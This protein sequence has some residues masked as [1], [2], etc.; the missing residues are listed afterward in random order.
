MIYSEDIEV[1]KELFPNKKVNIYFFHEKYRL[2]PA[3]LGRTIRKFTEM[4]LILV[5]GD[6]IELT[7]VGWKWVMANR[8]E[9][10][11]KKKEKYWKNIPVDM[12]QLPMEINEFYTPKRKN[13]DVELFKNIEGGE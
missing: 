12:L 5:D 10:F 8:Q 11:L 2:S 13:I 4:G 9:L 3:Q 1:I 6:Y 7:E